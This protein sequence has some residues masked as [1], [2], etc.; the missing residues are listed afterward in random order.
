MRVSRIDLNPGII[1]QPYEDNGSATQIIEL[2]QLVDCVWQPTPCSSTWNK[3]H[4]QSDVDFA[5]PIRNGDIINIQTQF[6]DYQNISPAFSCPPPTEYMHAV[7]EIEFVNKQTVVYGDSG[8]CIYYQFSLTFLGCSDVA[9][10]IE[11]RL[12]SY[13]NFDEWVAGTIDYY[14]SSG[15]IG[16]GVVTKIAANRMRIQW[17][18]DYFQSLFGRDIC[19]EEIMHCFYAKRLGQGLNH[20]PQQPYHK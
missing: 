13:N 3:N 11:T 18:C 15:V 1:F 2:P 14:I 20:P 10:H 16:G 8:Q 9:D 4:C 12:C 19:T 7:A 6:L 17:N 5:Q